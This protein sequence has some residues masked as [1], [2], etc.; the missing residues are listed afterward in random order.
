MYLV[1]LAEANLL[2]C[3]DLHTVDGMPVIL[4]IIMNIDTN[5]RKKMKWNISYGALKAFVIN[6]SVFMFMSVFYNI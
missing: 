5:Q 6:S 4:S 3:L 2:F 1:V